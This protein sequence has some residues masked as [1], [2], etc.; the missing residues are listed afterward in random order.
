[1]FNNNEY[2]I[3]NDGEESGVKA[4]DL[5]ELKRKYQAA[6]KKV[7][8][9]ENILSIDD[10]TEETYSFL[11]NSPKPVSYDRYL[12]MAGSSA[13]KAARAFVLDNVV[14]EMR[15]QLKDTMEEFP[16]MAIS[17]TEKLMKMLGL[18][19]TTSVKKL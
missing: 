11:F 7:Y 13:S 12:K 3:T 8:V 9:I 14:P 15:E 17:F 4:P 5:E 10:D 1:M 16:A 6:E 18:A 19:D 2:G